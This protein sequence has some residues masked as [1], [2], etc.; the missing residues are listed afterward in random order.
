MTTRRQLLVATVFGAALPFR[1]DAQS[2]PARIGMLSA[3]SLNESREIGSNH[4][5]R[6][7]GRHPR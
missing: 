6:G 2:R 7:S 4:E 1:T 3:R 5:G